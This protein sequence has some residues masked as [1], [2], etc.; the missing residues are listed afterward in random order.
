MLLVGVAAWA[1]PGG[2][3][4]FGGGSSSRSGGSS[5]SGGSSY[6]GG[7]TTSA[8][9]GDSGS[10]L[11]TIGVMVLFVVL[12]AGYNIGK[13]E[14]H[15]WS[16]GGWKNVTTG[17][18]TPALPAA[19]PAARNELARL[20]ES[21][22]AFSLVVFEDFIGALYIQVMLARG[23][24]E[25]ATL[26]A[27]LTPSAAQALGRRPLDGLT[28]VLVGALSVYGVRGL[29]P[30]S[31]RVVVE[32]AIESNL[33]RRD[34]RTG[35]EHASY[36]K[37]RWTLARAKTAKSRTPE[38]ARVFACPNCGAPLTEIFGGQCRHCR[39]NV[40]SGAF[41]W[42]LESLVVETTEPRGPMLTGTTAEQG[43]ELPTVFDAQVQPN[44]AE[45][46]K[47]D[48]ALRWDAL[49]ARIE[50]IFQTFQRAWCGRDLATMRPYLSDAL[51]TTQSYWVS[52][53]LRQGLQNI[54]ENAE[55]HGVELCRITS[56][57]Y[58]DAI[59]VRISASSL[60]FTVLAPAPRPGVP[61]SADA[62][63]V[64]AGNRSTRRRYTEYWTL[65]R[66]TRAK[67]PAKTDAACPRCGGPLVIT[68]AGQC[69]Y[70]QATVTRGDFDWVLS[71]IEQDDVYL[72]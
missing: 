27:Y 26:S 13:M 63:S 6:S 16:V 38:R 48:P 4:S 11:G 66:S 36:V 46:Q 72:G 28:H 1:R 31:S 51:F 41:D 71:R 40:A 50:L 23:R 17:S 49:S 56:D 55:L 45:L 24:G 30:A 59:T 54:T 9:G 8:D 68:M 39:Q 19:R 67:G 70:C 61:A 29:E 65:I 53:Y 21:D 62:G 14:L 52:E 5:H 43:N 18:A 2:G 34:S 57:A 44:F 42:V 15:A 3:Q 33:A 58:F 20:R 25:L 12:V 22:P 32:L 64:V 69:T 47:K 35:Q 60:D 7:S 37:E 10:I